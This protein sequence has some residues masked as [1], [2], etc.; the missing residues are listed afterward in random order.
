MVQKIYH[1]VTISIKNI[2]T[3]QINME[4]KIRQNICIVLMLRNLKNYVASAI[5]DIDKPAKKP[6]SLLLKINGS[7]IK[8]KTNKLCW[9]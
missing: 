5:L 8:N 2:L 6:D 4:L 3:I 7:S 1:W 9:P